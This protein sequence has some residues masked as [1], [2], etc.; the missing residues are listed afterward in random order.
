MEAD[1]GIVCSVFVFFFFLFLP[2]FPPVDREIITGVCMWNILLYLDMN[3]VSHIYF[4]L[5]GKKM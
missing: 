4:S 1:I 2:L 5:L 3:N